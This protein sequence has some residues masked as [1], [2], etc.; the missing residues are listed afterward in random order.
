[1]RS[2]EEWSLEAAT[3]HAAVCS[4]QAQRTIKIVSPS[5]RINGAGSRF[6]GVDRSVDEND[7]SRTKKVGRN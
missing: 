7:G 6:R 1:M 4:A 3:A 5:K 2:S